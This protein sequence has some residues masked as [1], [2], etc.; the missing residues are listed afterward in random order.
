MQ[1]ETEIS[2]F[3]IADDLHFSVSYLMKLPAAHTGCITSNNLIR[4]NNGLERR[5]KEAV[6]YYLQVGLTLSEALRIWKAL[7]RSDCILAQ[8]GNGYLR[9]KSKIVTALTGLLCASFLTKVFSSGPCK[10]YPYTSGCDFLLRLATPGATSFA[11]IRTLMCA[12]VNRK[13]PTSNLAELVKTC[14]H[15]WCFDNFAFFT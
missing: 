4:V 15:D 13:K 11:I 5:W 14:Y 3:Y 7:E 1:A 10:A 12:N 6:V 2:N 9:N 8:I